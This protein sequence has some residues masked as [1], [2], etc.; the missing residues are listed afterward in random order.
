[1]R[2]VFTALSYDNINSSFILKLN[3]ACIK[4]FSYL[5]EQVL[6]SFGFVNLALKNIFCD[7]T[8][9]DKQHKIFARLDLVFMNFETDYDSIQSTQL[10]ISD[11][12]LIDVFAKPSSLY[13]SGS[14]TE[15]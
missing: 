15:N 13:Q 10:S 8:H 5:K 9:Y 3:D 1:M 6:E 2:G 4:R 11:H 14:V 12:L 7:Y